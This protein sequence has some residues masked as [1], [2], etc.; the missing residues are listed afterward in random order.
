M[1][2]LEVPINA[3]GPTTENIHLLFFSLSCLIQGNL[4]PWVLKRKSTK[5]RELHMGSDWR[6]L[7]TFVAM[8]PYCAWLWEYTLEAPGAMADNLPGSYIKLPNKVGCCLQ[9]TH[10]DPWTQSP[11]GSNTSCRKLF[12]PG[13]NTFHQL[14]TTRPLRFSFGHRKCCW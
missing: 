4:I 8:Q 5:R 3:R 9:D 2:L 12:S 11:R 14:S 10:F 13:G 6:S 1:K 7:S